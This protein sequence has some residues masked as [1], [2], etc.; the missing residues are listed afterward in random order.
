M[1]K[2]FAENQALT[3]ETIR[4]LL[5]RS[6]ALSD[7]TLFKGQL[8][9]AIIFYEY[10]RY[11]NDPLFEQLADEQIEIALTVP[12]DMPAGLEGL[13]GIGLGFTYLLRHRF[14]EGD[15]DEILHAIDA[16]IETYEDLTQQESQDISNYH[17]YRQTGN[18]GLETYVL[19]RLWSNWT[20]IVNH[21][22]LTAL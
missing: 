7:V 11:T 3:W 2:L 14:V 18:T 10:S 21:Q 19:H 1:N 9:V 22:T 16:Q 6:K 12:K 8:G 15:L 4:F 13:S 5:F 17:H 20:G